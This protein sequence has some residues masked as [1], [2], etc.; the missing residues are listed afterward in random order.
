MRLTNHALYTFLMMLPHLFLTEI[1]D[2][3]PILL[4][5]SCRQFFVEVEAS[6]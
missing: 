2:T 4:N 3:K 1:Y 5:R 6:K